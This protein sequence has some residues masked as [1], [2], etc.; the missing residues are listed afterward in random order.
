MC[1]LG[2]AA[3]ENGCSAWFFRDPISPLI[4]RRLFYHPGIFQKLALFRNH[5]VLETC[6]LI[7]D[8]VDGDLLKPHLFPPGPVFGGNT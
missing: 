2:H 4:H 3:V 7:D 1:Y 6:F 5:T 8:D